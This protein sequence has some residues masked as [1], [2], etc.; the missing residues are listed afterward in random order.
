VAETLAVLV[1][2]SILSAFCLDFITLKKLMVP[3]VKITT[4]R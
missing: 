3:P 1:A 4:R 2:L